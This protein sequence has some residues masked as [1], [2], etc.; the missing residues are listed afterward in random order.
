M[1]LDKTREQIAKRM[2]A[3]AAM[4]VQNGCTEAEALS[5]M[6]KLTAMQSEYDVTLDPHNMDNE[7]MGFAFYPHCDPRIY[8]VVNAIGTLTTTK[9]F[10]VQE[11]QTV[12]VTGTRHDCEYAS[13]LLAICNNAAV[14]SYT[15]F[16]GT[17]TYNALRKEKKTEEAIRDAFY[18]GIA[19]RMA[20]HLMMMVPKDDTLKSTGTDLVVLTKQNNAKAYA[21]AAG[22]ESKEVSTEVALDPEA[23]AA[24]QEAGDKVA[25]NRGIGTNASQTRYLH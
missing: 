19:E 6:E 25:F 5:A 10:V 23:H 22:L 18:Y 21:E 3:L 15:K 11:E 1:S 14:S 9:L 20:I 12:I 4:T 8:A 16:I 13:Y 24:G 17:P 2:R 7:G